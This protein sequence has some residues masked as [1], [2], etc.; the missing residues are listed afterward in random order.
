MDKNVQADVAREDWLLLKKA[1]V[2]ILLL[3]NLLNGV[4][5]GFEVRAP[6]ASRRSSNGRM[7][8]DCL[9]G[10]FYLKQLIRLNNFNQIWPSLASGG[11][12]MRILNFVFVVINSCSF[13]GRF[14]WRLCK[15][16]LRYDIYHLKKAIIFWF[17]LWDLFWSLFVRSFLDPAERF[18]I[19]F[20]SFL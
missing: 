8:L 14:L 11:S 4:Y 16:V 15:V 12:W 6:W 5:S 20:L 19:Y 13:D 7:R 3:F 9:C 10:G 17:C 1:L 18:L 2:G